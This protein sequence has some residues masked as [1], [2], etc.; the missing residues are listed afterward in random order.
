MLW[1]CW[2]G[3]R[4]GIWSVKMSGGLLAWLFVRSDVQIC[5]WPSW[6]HCHSLSLASE[7]SRLVLPFWYRLTWVVPEN[8][9]WELPCRPKVLQYLHHP[10]C[11]S[12][13]IVFLIDTCFLYLSVFIACV[14]SSVFSHLLAIF[15]TYLSSVYH[16]QLNTELRTQV[17]D[18]YKSASS[19]YTII[20]KK[21]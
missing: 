21:T 2:L 13:R 12:W 10:L 17:S 7:K 20:V 19:L 16:T 11:I 14:V 15:A 9:Y 4:K 3:G 8:Y 18:T 6:C 5:I 1:L